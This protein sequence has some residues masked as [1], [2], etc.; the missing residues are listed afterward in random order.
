[1]EAYMTAKEAAEYLKLAERTLVRLAHEGK[2]PGVKIGGQWR[3]RR[4]L[5][6]EYLD[7]LASQSVV[8]SGASTAQ[9]ADVGLSE[10]LTM[11]QVIPELRA[12][13]RAEVIHTMVEH[14]T[15][16][17]LVKDQSWLEAALNARERLVPTAVP[18]GVAFLHARRR[19]AD[20]F[21][22]QFIALGRSQ[23][24]LVFGS[25][26]M[27]KTRLF[28]L[29]ALRNDTLHLKWLS[30]LAWIVRSPGRMGRILEAENANQIHEAL[31][32]GADALPRSLKPSDA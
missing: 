15:G 12:S 18:E 27:G 31:L 11:D 10:I 29:L 23:E 25:P 22:Q 9:T 4:A 1:M 6:D 13:N 16:L 21:P 2:I 26:D 20:M 32:E 24:G 19:A 28:F 17:G 8:S 3:F 14:V 30:R 7:T 5:L